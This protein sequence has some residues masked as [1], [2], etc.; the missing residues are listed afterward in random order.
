MSTEW[1]ETDGLGGFAM[2][3]LGTAPTRRY[4]GLLIA[5]PRGTSRRHLFLAR[6]A[7]SVGPR[8]GARSDLF[9]VHH[10]QPRRQEPAVPA[11]LSSFSIDP[12]PAWQFETTDWRVRREVL[13]PKGRPA[14]LC[15]WENLASS[16]PLLL[17]IRPFLVCRDLDRL[18]FHNEALDT[19]S[20]GADDER[21]F[22]PYPALPTVIARVGR[23]GTAP[24]WIEAGEWDDGILLETDRAR[25]YDAI[26]DHFSPGYFELELAAGETV[27]VAFSID[28]AIDDPAALREE[29]LALRQKARRLRAHATS[30]STTRA[31]LD[32]RADDFLQ[33]DAHGRLGICAGFPWFTEWGRDTFLALPG[34]T[35]ARGRV[36]QCARVLLGAVRFLHRG[37]LPNIF[38][39]DRDDSHYGSVDAA[40]WFARAV[41]LWRRAGGDRPD[42][43]RVLDDALIAIAAEY[44]DGTALGIVAD[45]DGLLRCG[46]EELNATWMDARLPSGPVTPRDG[47]PVEIEA[48][49]CALLDQVAEL[50]AKAD[51][52]DATMWRER[53]QRA[54]ASFL[55]AFWLPATGRAPGYLA[56]R[57]DPAGNPDPRIRPNMVLAAALPRS[58][59]SREQKAEVLAITERELLTPRGLRTLAPSDPSYVGRYEGDVVS[60]DRAY[61]QGTAWP[62]LLGAYAEL[63]LAVEGDGARPRLLELLDGL[64]PE[65]DRAGLDH[66]SEV[67]DGDAPQRPGGTIA[68]A[69]NTGEILRAYD[70]L[71]DSR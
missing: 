8:A 17:R 32:A 46:S 55:A 3:T 63:A 54:N 26:E 21:R 38:G 23:S 18:H 57:I 2:G 51:R 60:R 48:L 62:W 52:A 45:S 64:L 7:D 43:A 25:G 42:V 39:Q 68:Q 65:L 69:W 19:E 20:V 5:T 16:E 59:L 22:Q 29:V 11:A 34:L 44:H 58:P 71:E 1:L 53:A 12:I 33:I 67:F 40:L 28:K 14:V 27:T 35:L 9:V 47:K 24:R 66:V 61:H 31:R 13:V 30:G 56:D 15:H 36:D 6:V 49:W 41:D 50:C 37:L 70:L 4:H 10:D